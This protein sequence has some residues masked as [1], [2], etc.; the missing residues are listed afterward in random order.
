MKLNF[1]DI[2]KFVINLD[3]RPERLDHFKNEMAWIGWDYERFSA[4]DTNS[5]IGCAKSHQELAKKSL[6]MNDHE[7]FMFL[8]DDIFFMP[9]AKDQILKCEIELSNINFDFF[10]LAPSLHRPV[11]NFTDNLLDI[12]NLPPK[13]EE[14]HRE[15]F[16]TSAFIVNKKICDYIVNWDTNKYINNTNQHL[17]IDEFLV[18]AV[19]NNNICL[20]SSLPIVTQINDFSD[21]NHGHYNNHY[22]MTY[23]WNLYTQNK[24]EPALLDLAYCRNKK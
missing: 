12:S 5:Y 14:K 10:H 8:E 17:P 2:P 3:R 4:I 11:N 15:V 22:L 1:K 9:Y 24:L 20:A 18:K 13:N 6:D 23:N 7:Y 16:G 21:I 19:Y